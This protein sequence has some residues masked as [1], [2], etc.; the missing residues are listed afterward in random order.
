[1]IMGLTVDSIATQG[2]SIKKEKSK[3][4]KRVSPSSGNG[5]KSIR[6]EGSRYCVYRNSRKVSCHGTRAMARNK[7]RSM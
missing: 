6:K 7:M 5:R 1:M 4:Y 3:M 2:V